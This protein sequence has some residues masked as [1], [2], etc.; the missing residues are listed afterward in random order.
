[1][2]KMEREESKVRRE[3][4]ESDIEMITHRMIGHDLNLIT[5]NVDLDLIRAA[6]QLI[7]PTIRG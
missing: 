3:I 5:L 7:T 2:K 6:D 4:L 1:M